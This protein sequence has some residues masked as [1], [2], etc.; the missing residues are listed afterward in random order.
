MAAGKT[1]LFIT[2][3]LASTM[4]TDR[5]FV[6]S[7][8]KIAET[9]THDELMARSGIYAEMFNAQKQWYKK[10]GEGNGNGQEE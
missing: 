6:I 3:R 5:I 9:G 4:I 10:A 1:A 8:G 2:H 7:D